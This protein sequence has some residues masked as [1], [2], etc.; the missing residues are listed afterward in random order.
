MLV[1]TGAG[2]VGLTL[3]RACRVIIFDPSWN[4]SQDA[5]AVDRA[6]RIGQNHEVLVYR[7]FLAGGIEEKMYEKQVHKT[8]LEKTLFSEGKA[9]ERY[10]DKNELCKVFAQVPDGSCELLQ[11]F[12]KE[13]VAEVP[14]AYLHDLVRAHSSVIGI[15]NHSNIYSQK[16]KGA[17]TD[18][19]CFVAKKLKHTDDIEQA[20]E[21][22]PLVSES[23]APGSDAA[24]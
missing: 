13:K 15:S 24:L 6:Y 18:A 20:D 3:T 14:D 12:K 22:S 23:D 5:Q 17:F 11:R 10:F 7:L 21:N 4:P 16:R 1:S 2:G 8:G 9:E 19:V